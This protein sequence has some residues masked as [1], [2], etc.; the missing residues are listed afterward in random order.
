MLSRSSALPDLE[1]VVNKSWIQY[2]EKG[3]VG[4]DP[5]VLF[6]SI[7]FYKAYEEK[8]TT[9]NRTLYSVELSM[10]YLLPSMEWYLDLIKAQKV[11]NNYGLSFFIQAFVKMFRYYGDEQYLLEAK[12]LAVS[13]INELIPTPHGLG[14]ANPPNLNE[15]LN[16][17]AYTEAVSLIPSTAEFAFALL[18]LF[19]VTADSYYLD[20][21]GKITQSF[22]RDYRHK[23]YGHRI[24]IDYST[25]GD[26]THI[27]N[28]NALAVGCICLVNRLTGRDSENDFI[29][30]VYE[31][32]KDYLH[33]VEIPYCG[34]EDASTNK[35]WKDCD[36]YHTG[37]TLRGVEITCNYLKD[38]ETAEKIKKITQDFFPYFLNGNKEIVK[39]KNSAVM[40]IHGV[41]EYI[42]YYS[43]HLNELPAHYLETVVKNIT[44]TFDGKTFLYRKI[45]GK[46]V[47][48]YMPRWGHAPMMNAISS[49][50]M[51]LKN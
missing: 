13:V 47:K 34:R 17:V 11:K 20:I 43:M 21:A 41:A 36:V 40:D 33:S 19:S 24:S 4:H 7:K 49:L 25:G 28:A 10:L 42:L 46:K 5:S 6:K 27:L 14:M 38:T 50:M 32:L 2:R 44:G 8:Q 37:F 51:A 18:E 48:C 9:I 31:Y 45:Y 35:N 39:M 23:T 1:D 29:Q 26:G 22:A 30:G 16:G 3:F 12:K 15:S